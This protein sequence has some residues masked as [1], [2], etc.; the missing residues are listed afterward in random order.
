VSL[1]G[2]A[3]NPGASSRTVRAVI[4]LKR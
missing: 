3:S 2:T 1:T 4:R